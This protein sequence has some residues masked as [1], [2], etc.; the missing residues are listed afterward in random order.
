MRTTGELGLGW[1][2]E[3]FHPG[4]EDAFLLVPADHPALDAAVIR[5]ILQAH[6]DFPDR[7]IIVPTFE[8]RRGHPTL[9]GWNHVPGI[10]A[11]S[12]GKGLNTYLREQRGETL[13]LPVASAA[14]LCDLDTPEDYEEVLRQYA[15]E[16]AAPASA[17]LAG[18]ACSEKRSNS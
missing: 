7:S 8:A 11:H 10:R 9:I 17:A 14:V 18:A 15:S 2:E 4:A 3:Q 16:H 12:A 6:L 1:L 13:E 5:R